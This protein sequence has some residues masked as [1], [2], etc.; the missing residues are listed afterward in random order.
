FHP[1]P[2]VQVLAAFTPILT[3]NK[4]EEQKIDNVKDKQ[5]ELPKP[6]I[7]TEGKTDWIHLKAAYLKF[8]DSGY[9]KFDLDFD[10]F[11]E[12]R[13][14]S[15]TLDA[16]K[17]HAR[18]NNHQSRIFIFDRDV[19][20]I[21]DDVMSETTY[22]KDWGNNVYSFPLPIPQHRLKTPEIR[23]EFF[24]QDDDLMK[25]DNNGRRLF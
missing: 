8:K 23:I 16:C 19:Q 17:K 11:E 21:V 4:K 3:L 20:A 13:G 7:I 22:Y 15:D 9:I 1:L 12:S 25:K 18:N 6:I 14:D 10:E 2:N 24:Y 5:T